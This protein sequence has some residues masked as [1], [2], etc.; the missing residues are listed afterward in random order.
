[1]IIIIYVL[2]LTTIFKAVSYCYFLICQDSH[3]GPG[4]N[5][6]FSSTLTS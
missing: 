6:F 4:F 1:M 5:S 2:I 3:S